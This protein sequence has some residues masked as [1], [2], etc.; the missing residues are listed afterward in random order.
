M[1]RFFEGVDRSQSV[2]FPER[3]EDYV[4]EDNPVRVV[5]AFVEHLDLTTQG[6]ERAIAQATGRPGIT[7]RRCLR[8]TSTDTSTGCSRAVGWSAKR[9][10]T[11]S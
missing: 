8:S 11:S 3:L 1:S 4:G 6:F 10:E 9:S 2:L 5:D 7:R